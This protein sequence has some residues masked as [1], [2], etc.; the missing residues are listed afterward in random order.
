MHQRRGWSGICGRKGSSAAAKWT[1][2]P[3]WGTFSTGV[4]KEQYCRFSIYGEA[5]AKRLMRFLGRTVLCPIVNILIAHDVI[6][7]EVIAELHLDDLD[8]L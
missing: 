8:K 7:T 2:S 5:G 4:E 6:F 1:S 3:L